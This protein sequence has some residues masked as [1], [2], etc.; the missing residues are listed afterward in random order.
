VVL[1]AWYGA[2]DVLGPVVAREH[3]GGPAAWGLIT[4]ADAVGLII[5][6]VIG[7]RYTARRP[8]LFV[9]LIGATCAITPLALAALLPLPLICIAAVG[10]GISLEVMMVQWTVTMAR[11]VPPDLL[12]RVSS[13][14]VL[15]A[16]SAMPLGALVAGPIAAAVGVPATQYGAAALIVVA[17]ALTLLAPEVRH[18]R[19]EPVSGAPPAAEVPAGARAA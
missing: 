19:A 6:G 16:V 5:G 13:Y 18:M 17:S 8:I 15:G 9:V 4:A 7:M 10:L 2:F 12:A 3:L 14:D 11:N 1:A